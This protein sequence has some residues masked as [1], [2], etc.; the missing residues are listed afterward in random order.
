[1][2]INIIKV[3]FDS[4]HKRKLHLQQITSVLLFKVTSLFKHII[5]MRLLLLKESY[6]IINRTQHVIIVSVQNLKAL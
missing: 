5:Q 3:C 2:N 4:S 6:C 1:M